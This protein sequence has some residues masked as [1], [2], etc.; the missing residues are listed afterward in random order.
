MS[1]ASDFDG[2]YS[3]MEDGV[4]SKA[5]FDKHCFLV[6]IEDGSWILSFS[7]Q[8]QQEDEAIYASSELSIGPLKWTTPDLPRKWL[9]LCGSEWVLATIS[10]KRV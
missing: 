2:F 7:N 10:V 1:G 6:L 5:G 9:Q 4:Y 3:L 8:R